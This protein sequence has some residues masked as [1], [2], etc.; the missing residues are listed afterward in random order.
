MIIY[1][2]VGIS[3]GIAVAL[4]V[5]FVVTRIILPDFTKTNNEQLITMANEKLGA[6]KQDIKTDLE[7]KKDVIEDL[8][9]RVYEELD[10]TD[11]KLQS[12]EKERIGSFRELKNELENQRKLTEQLRTTTES[13]SKVLSSN[14]MRGQWG[15]RVASDLLL[16]NGFVKGIDFDFN[17]EQD[18]GTRPDFTIYLPNKAKINVDAK[19]P[20]QNLKKMTETSDLGTKNELKKMFEKDVRE[21]IRQVTTRDYINPSED[22]VDFVILFIPNEMV[23][24]FIYESMSEVWVEAMRQKVVLAGPFTFTAILRMVRQA[25]ENFKY[26]KNVQKII[27]YIKTFEIEFKKYNEEFTKIGERIESLTKQYNMVSTTRT[28]QLNKS[29]DKIRLED[30]STQ[31]LQLEE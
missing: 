14:Q 20:Y 29:I 16:M 15:E 7:N 28:N 31:Q 24:S 1:I 12:A 11:N 30:E 22:T 18:K 13:L 8:V 19:F 6:Q 5:I 21:K 9:K 27:G 3:V 10:K 25:Y 23:F 2:I 26:Q 17:K 4:A